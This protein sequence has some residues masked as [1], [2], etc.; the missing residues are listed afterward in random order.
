MRYLLHIQ[1]AMQTKHRLIAM[2][3]LRL[4]LG[5]YMLAFY[6][7]HLF[8]YELFWGV[9]GLVSY[10]T[11]RT[12]MLQSHD[13]SLFLLSPSDAI[14]QLIIGIGIAV[15]IAYT[16]GYRTRI[17]S[18][19][20]Y[21]LTWSVYRRDWYI[22][23]GGDNLLYI[24]S[25]YMMFVDCGAYF[26]LDASRVKAVVKTKAYSFV[27]LLHNFGVLAIIVQLCIVYL[28]SVFY[29]V[30]GHM[31]QDGTAI[32]YVLR[33]NQF[34]LTGLGQALYHNAILVTT[35]T[36]ATLLFQ[37]AWPWLIWNR[38]A[39]PFLAISA[40]SLHLSIAIFMGLYWFSFVM[41]ASECVIFDDSEYVRFSQWTDELLLRARRL[42]PALGKEAPSQS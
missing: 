10:D 39:R 18:I 41:I 2:S 14:G 33:S 19:L 26:S 28:T 34:N 15:T 4:A 17:T 30:Q 32:Y 12:A 5:I 8:Q 20:F 16:L 9:N 35:L 38:Y 31:W 21:I 25:F 37:A 3:I 36:Y 6:A 13:V 29:K 22:L 27:N 23:N 42:I 40:V 11:F 7:M 24:L 1:Q